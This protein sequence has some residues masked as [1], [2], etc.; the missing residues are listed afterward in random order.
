M[1]ERRQATRDAASPALCAA[2]PPST[3][4]AARCRCP[5]PPPIALRRGIPRAAP[6]AE[7][8]QPV[9]VVVVARAA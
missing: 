5:A 4:R 7:P 6:G 8:H 2:R 3:A 1:Q 9:E